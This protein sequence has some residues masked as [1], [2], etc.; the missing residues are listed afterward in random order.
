MADDPFP[1]ER[2]SSMVRRM[3]AYL[4][5]SWHL[6]REPLLSKARR[7]AVVGAA[8]Y[9]VSPVDLVPGVVPV[10]GQLDDIAV[11][12]AALRIALA[13]LSPEHRQRHLAS[14]GL[15]DDH[16]AEDLRTVGVT[17]A[18]IGRAGFRTT[19]RVAVVGTRSARTGAGVAVHTSRVIADRAM[20]PARAAA[21]RAGAAAPL[22]KAAATRTAA[23]G[24]RALRMAGSVVGRRSR[25][26]GDVA[27][28]GVTVTPVEPP[29]L[30]PPPPERRRG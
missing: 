19:R 26:A 6:A 1:R 25:P 12:I 3:P 10:V 28:P 22:A 4:R 29:L 23:A 5:L 8:G 30:P 9:L 13:G 15:S 17:T 11:A 20:P 18:W 24:N 21:T 27:E 16:L 7:M 14:V 2:L